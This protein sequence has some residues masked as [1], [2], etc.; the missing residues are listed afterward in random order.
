[1]LNKVTLIGNLGRDPENR[2]FPNGGSVCNVS[3]A[4]TD[5]WRDRAS[6][7]RRE[8]TEWHNLVFND[9]LAEIASQYL[10]KGSRIYVEGNIRTR[11]YQD[12]S[13]QDRYITEIRVRE[14]KMLDSRRDAQ[15]DSQ[16]WAQGQAQQQPQQPYNAPAEAPPAAGAAPTG[17]GDGGFSNFEDDIPF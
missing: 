5:T 14:M 2:T 4:T 13:G 7:E 15:G 16:G 3:L 6:G 10:R 17:G 8:A 11:K 9:R 1:M 12:K